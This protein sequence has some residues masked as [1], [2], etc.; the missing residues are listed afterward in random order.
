M[1]TRNYKNINFDDIEEIIKQ[2]TL[3]E[4][5]NE[6]YQQNRDALRKKRNEKRKFNQFLKV[7]LVLFILG[8]VFVFLVSINYIQLIEIEGT[9]MEPTFMKNSHSV[10]N[11]VAYNNAEP[12][13]FDTIAFELIEGSEYYY[14]KRIIGMPGEIIWIQ[15]GSIFINNQTLLDPI[16]NSIMFESLSAKVPYQLGED[17]YFVLGDNRNESLDSRDRNFGYVKRDLI[18]GKIYEW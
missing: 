1:D 16:G 12:E 7:R 3:E 5:P 10:I 8:I 18:I 4:V 6:V 17:E 14:I 13:R 11:K 15:S 2:A 9:S